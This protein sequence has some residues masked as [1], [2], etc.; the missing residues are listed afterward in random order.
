MRTI[1]NTAVN[2]LIAQAHD[3]PTLD[4]AHSTLPAT[5][6]VAAPFEEQGAGAAQAWAAALDGYIAESPTWSQATAPAWRR[7]ASPRRL[8]ELMSR[9][10]GERMVPTFQIRRRSPVREAVGRLVL[11]IAV[12]VSTGVVIGAY[13]AFSGGHRAPAAQ[14]AA[15]ARPADAHPAAPAIPARAVAAPAPVVTPAPA[16]A[17][18]PVVAPVVAPA[19]PALVDVRIDSTPSGATVTLVDRGRTQLVGDTPVDAAVDPSR[20]YDLVFTYAD[21]PPHVEHLDARTT[22][23][24]EVALDHHERVERASAEPPPRASRTRSEPG[25][26]TLMISS[27]PPCE[28]VI[29]GRATGLITPQR[30]ISLSAGSHRVTL[31]NGE[32]SIRK[33]LTVQIAANATEKVIEDLM[34]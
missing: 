12:L 14:L 3:E 20:E 28:I 4:T 23:R 26:G 18:A 16:V 10:D 34:K 29:D 17:P 11:P 32:K 5:M 33:T 9:R 1:E 15:A 30:A 31:R 7:P 27:K 21:G 6:P 24:I 25:V 8:Y 2:E 19:P 22:R 13:V